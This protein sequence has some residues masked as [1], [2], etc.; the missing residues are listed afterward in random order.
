MPC[1]V[2]LACRARPVG[3]AVF[4]AGG[5]EARPGAGPTGRP[6]SVIRVLRKLRS[7]SFAE[8]RERATQKASALLE[9]AGVGSTLREPTDEELERQL[10]AS[11]PA[12]SHQ[13]HLLSHFR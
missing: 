1:A 7:R 10:V 6:T 3:S 12:A 4:G 11:S 9:V 8:L 5:R 2:H 13:A